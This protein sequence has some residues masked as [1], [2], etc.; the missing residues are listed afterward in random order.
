MWPFLILAIV[1]FILEVVGLVA[2]AGDRQ[3]LPAVKDA[4]FVLIYAILLI[5]A[6]RSAHA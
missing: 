5:V 6:L 1:F 2:S 3:I 4:V